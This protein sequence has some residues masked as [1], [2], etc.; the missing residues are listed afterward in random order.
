MVDLDEVPAALVDID[1]VL[2]LLGRESVPGDLTALA[3]A[4]G[5]SLQIQAVAAEGELTPEQVQRITTPAPPVVS[6]SDAATDFAVPP[7]LL[8]LIFGFLFYFAVLTFGM[9]IAQSVVEEKQSRVVE[10]LVAAV[11]VRWLLAGKVLG[12]ALMAFGQV[13]LIVAVGVLGALLTDAGDAVTEIVGASGWF[14]GFFALGFLMLACL[15][16]VAGS[17]A[18][19][20]EDLQNTTVVMQI[21]VMLPFFSAVLITEPGVLQRVLSYFPL[22]AP[23]MMPARVVS[24]TAAPWEPWLAGL[25]VLLTAAAFVA[26]GARLYAGSV[27]NMGNRTKLSAAWRKGSVNA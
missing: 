22:T 15:W 9:S 27:L 13:T 20:I 23:L 19:R 25:I 11:P 21:A 14:L 17:L 2:T 24:E 18:T 10:L 26:I 12:N 1:G 7:I 5:R 8:T 3:T 16:A 4:A 6:L